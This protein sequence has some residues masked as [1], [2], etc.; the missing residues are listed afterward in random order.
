M[1][2]TFMSISVGCSDVIFHTSYSTAHCLFLAAH[3]FLDKAFMAAGHQQ[4]YC[5]IQYWLVLLLLVDLPIYVFESKDLL[6][7]RQG[8]CWYHGIKGNVPL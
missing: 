6:A 3:I 5:A 4:H 1:S 7:L 2:A 8:G